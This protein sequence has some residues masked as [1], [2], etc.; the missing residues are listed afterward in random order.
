MQATYF[1]CLKKQ[2]ALF[3]LQVACVACIQTSKNGTYFVQVNIH[4][5]VVFAA[6]CLKTC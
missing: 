3:C 5:T 6:I 2:N 4:L 1:L